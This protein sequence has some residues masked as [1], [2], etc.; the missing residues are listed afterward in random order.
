MHYEFKFEHNAAMAKLILFLLSTLLSVQ[1]FALESKRIALITPRSPGDAF[2]GPFSTFSAAAAKHFGYRFETFY[3]NG[4]HHE[5]TSLVEKAM[6]GKFDAIILSN[7]KM[8][9]RQAIL[10]AEKY[11]IPVVFVTGGFDESEKMGE[12]RIKYPH[13]IGQLLPDDRQ[14]GEELLN[15]LYQAYKVKW[16][17]KIPH[18]FG[19]EGNISDSGSYERKRGAQSVID[20][21]SLEYT[22]FVA[23]NWNK[24]LAKEKYMTF[25]KSRYPDIDLIWCASDLMAIGAVEA[26]KSQGLKPGIDFVSGGVDWSPEGLKAVINGDIIATVGGHIFQGGWALVLLY[27]YFNGFDFATE[28]TTFNTEMKALTNKNIHQFNIKLDPTHWDKINFSDFSK[29]KNPS[30]KDYDFTLAHLFRL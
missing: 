6:I 27:D 29:A 2:W 13:W 30:I 4:D 20:K 28:R 5:M 22:Q 14:A 3:A 15:V 24:E 19:I 11:R 12:P 25:K 7:F 26:A 16:P 1:L 9:G 10:L 8:Q 18:F 17:N 23:A 21:F